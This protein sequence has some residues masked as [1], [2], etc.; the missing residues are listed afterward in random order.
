MCTFEAC[1]AIVGQESRSDPCSFLGAHDGVRPFFAA[2]LSDG[3]IA[4]MHATFADGSLRWGVNGSQIALSFPAIGIASVTF[5]TGSHVACCL[6]SG[7]VYLVPEND[8]PVAAILAPV[9]R[10]SS[11]Q[12][13]QGFHAGNM[14][15]KGITSYSDLPVFVYSGAG[16]ILQVYS[17]VLLS[18]TEKDSV[19]RELVENGSVTLL[20]DFLCSLR[21]E[22]PL[23]I[24]DLWNL[25]RDEFLH[26][27]DTPT[28]S[29]LS[30]A[31]FANTRRL[32]IELSEVNDGSQHE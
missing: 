23:L 4:V 15:V 20:R 19:L 8:T 2:A 16:G 7:T 28:F 3:T 32:L 26:A 27:N 6:R 22:D 9:E 18:Q 14:L 13:L 11:T 24:M 12:Y 30:S 29:M 17:C 21:G 10:E 25:A 5:S 31:S 1:L